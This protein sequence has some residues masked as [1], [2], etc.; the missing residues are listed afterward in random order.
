[1]FDIISMHSSVSLYSYNYRIINFAAS[2]IS[3]EFLEK[4]P[5]IPNTLAHIEKF[6]YVYI[7]A[8]MMIE[9]RIV[10]DPDNFLEFFA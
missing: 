7:I 9:G 3:S 1:M 6:K 10:D 8:I 4:V 5:P 2:H